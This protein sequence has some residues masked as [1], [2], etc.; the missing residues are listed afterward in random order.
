MYEKVEMMKQL[1]NCMTDRSQRVRELNG[2]MSR[3]DV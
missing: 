2:S 1:M 3:G